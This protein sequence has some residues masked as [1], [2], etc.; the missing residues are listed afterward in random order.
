MFVQ[1]ALQLTKTTKHTEHREQTDRQQG[2]EF[3]QGFEGDGDHQAFMFFP[4]GDV[5]G[6][7]QDGEQ[8]DGE[9]EAQGDRAGGGFL[10]EYLNGFGDRADLQGD[11]G[12]DPGEHEQGDQY[13][14]QL[15]LVA[16]GE[17]IGQ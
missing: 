16:K 7:E 9:A 12:Q 3:D 1:P 4:C 6:A 13:P 10:G 8:G 14:G 17:Q 11:V 2:D 15:A 5:A